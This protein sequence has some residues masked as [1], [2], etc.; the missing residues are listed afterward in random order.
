MKQII[1]ILALLLGYSAFAAKDVEIVTCRDRNPNS[2]NRAKVTARFEGLKGS[3]TLFHLPAEGQYDEAKMGEEAK[4]ILDADGNLVFEARSWTLVISQEP[5]S[6]GYRAEL[7]VR[8]GA[9]RDLSLYCTI[10]E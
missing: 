1:M 4:Q 2:K 6:K 8:A 3:F 5:M 10:N 9:A 7:K